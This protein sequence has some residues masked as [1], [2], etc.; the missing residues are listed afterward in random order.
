MP[1]ACPC[2]LQKSGLDIP[3]V[4]VS[5]AIGEETAIE[6]MRP[7]LTTIYENNMSRLVSRN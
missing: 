5:G 4:V 7:E 1:P 3:F 2:N 6:I